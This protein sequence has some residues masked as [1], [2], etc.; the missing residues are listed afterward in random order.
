M[1]LKLSHV[2][3]QDEKHPIISKLWELV[4]KNNNPWI[5]GILEVTYWYHNFGEWLRYNKSLFT[6]YAGIDFPSDG[7]HIDFER[8]KQAFTTKAESDISS[9][10]NLLWELEDI[11][12]DD[13]LKYWIWELEKA[14]LL[15]TIQDCINLLR[16]ALNSIDFELEKAWYTHGMT[17]DEIQ[18]KISMNEKLEKWVFGWNILDDNNKQESEYAL[19]YLKRWFKEYLDLWPEKQQKRVEQWYAS[20]VLDSSEQKRLSWYISTIS[21]KLWELWYSTEFEEAKQQE[22]I[23]R[24]F[25]KDFSHIRIPRDIVKNFF[26]WTIDLQEMRQNVAVTSKGSIYDGPTTLEIPDSEEFETL[27]FERVCWL[28]VHEISWHYVNQANHEASA[29]WDVRT[30]GNIEKEEWL[31]MLSEKMVKW[32]WVTWVD[33]MNASFIM[34]MASEIFAWEELKDFIDLY[35]DIS[36]RKSSPEANLARR[37]RNYPDDY[38]WVQHKDVAYVRWLLRVVDY[39]WADGGNSKWNIEDLF[40]WKVWLDSIIEWDMRFDEEKML[41]PILNVEVMLF[42]IMNM[43]WENKKLRHEDFVAYMGEKYKWVVSEASLDKLKNEKLGP[44]SFRQM[45]W[46]ISPIISEFTNQAPANDNSIPDVLWDTS[47]RINE[48]VKKVA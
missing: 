7:T 13:L 14:T 22:N 15:K 43:I 41:F 34:V 30:S 32:L 9:F 23:T 11:P 45:L 5:D 37:K 31:A 16:L 47:D 46:T 1:V 28:L 17:Q 21:Q 39:I 33:A 6:E 38:V 25:F 20:R 18:V 12:I 36:E 24:K 42:Y 8:L 3:Q 4:N 27:D 40:V 26:Q 48:I 10:S 44:K 35:M 2:E 29:Y 19:Q